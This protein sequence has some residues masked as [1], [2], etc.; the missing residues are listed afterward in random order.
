MDIQLYDYLREVEN[1]RKA[2]IEHCEEHALPVAKNAT[3]TDIIGALSS[4]NN[5]APSPQEPPEDLNIRDYENTVE[6]RFFDADG[7]LLKQE[8]IPKGGSTTPPEVNP[9]MDPERLTFNKWV[10]AIGEV[11][12]NLQHDVDYGATYNLNNNGMYLFIRLSYYSGL[13][14]TIPLIQTGAADMV[15]IDW[16][17]GTTASYNTTGAK[18]FTHTYADYGEYVISISRALEQL[19]TQPLYF[20]TSSSKRLLGSKNVCTAVYKL[21]TTFACSYNAYDCY[22]LETLVTS[23][24]IYWSSSSSPGYVAT[25]VKNFIVPDAQKAYDD[26]EILDQFGTMYSIRRLIFSQYALRTTLTNIESTSTSTN[27]TMP[28][29]TSLSIQPSAQL[30]KLII[31]PIYTLSNGELIPC[32]QLTALIKISG[33]AEF[34]T[35]SVQ[36]YRRYKRPVTHLIC[37]ANLWART[38]TT[39]LMTGAVTS[40]VYHYHTLSSVKRLEVYNAMYNSTEYYNVPVPFYTAQYDSSVLELGT[41]NGKTFAEGS[42][43]YP[44]L[45][46][47]HVPSGL[48]SFKVDAISAALPGLKYLYLPAAFDFSIRLTGAYNLCAESL[49]NILNALKNNVGYTAKTIY[50]LYSAAFKHAN[51]YVCLNNGIYELCEKTATGAMPLYKAFSDKNWT[52]TLENTY[53]GNYFV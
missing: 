11:Y 51:I 6:V 22:N 43:N 18:D 47:L 29:T 2:L 15:T 50:F 37:Y 4:I 33:Y 27:K 49:V 46:T 5:Y 26:S 32:K 8:I 52:I 3:Y 17:D 42:L 23:K 31:P 38:K 24:G 36:Y 20:N 9:N 21:Y 7:T 14:I 44:T 13:S 53:F 48:T 28:Y 40:S 45:E 39:G 16:G 10:S 12:D 1:A 35:S 25:Y 41:L 34:T 30:D 19:P